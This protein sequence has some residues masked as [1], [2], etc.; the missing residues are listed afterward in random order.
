[1]NRTRGEAVVEQCCREA[2]E[3]HKGPRFSNVRNALLIGATI[4]LIGAPASAQTPPAPRPSG[5]HTMHLIKLPNGDYTVPLAELEGSGASGKVTV[6]PQGLKTLVT[7]QVSGKPKH[8]HVFSLK[9]GGDCGILGTPAAVSLTPALT[10]EPSR[11]VI[12]LPIGDLASK[13]YV[14]TAQDATAREQYKEA[15]ARF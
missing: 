3:I 4:A 1:V 2:A 10:G 15:C 5:H 7:I 6:R 8:K 13:D 11:T 14:L 12:A 9:S